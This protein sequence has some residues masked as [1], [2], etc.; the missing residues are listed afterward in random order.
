MKN[1]TVEEVADKL[2]KGRT[3]TWMQIRNGELKSF[4]IG[5]R[6]LVAE[7]ALE[8]FIERAKHATAGDAT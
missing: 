3:W 2:R 6:R 5:A 1:Y 8:A 7:D 4:K